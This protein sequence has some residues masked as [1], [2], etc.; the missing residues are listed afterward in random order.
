MILKYS[1]ENLVGKF[2]KIL[3]YIISDLAVVF[4]NVK[5]LLKST[6]SFYTSQNLIFN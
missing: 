6:L 3:H 1:L 2:K 5:H 4:T